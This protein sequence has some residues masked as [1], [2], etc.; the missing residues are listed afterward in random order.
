MLYFCVFFFHH[1]LPSISLSVFTCHTVAELGSVEAR[2]PTAERENREERER[3]RAGGMGVCG[4]MVECWTLA[5]AIH[6]SL[7]Y[8]LP[9]TD[10][11]WQRAA[12]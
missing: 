3:E 10:G 11:S 12:L 4:S 1:A 9:G 6:L 7:S 2:V 5:Q 8:T